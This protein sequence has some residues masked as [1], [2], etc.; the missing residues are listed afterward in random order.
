MFEINNDLGN[1]K[2]KSWHNW[3]HFCASIVFVITVYYSYDHKDIIISGLTAWAVGI[4]WDVVDGFKPWY[5]QFK[6]NYEQPKW[7]NWLRQNFN[8]S[9]KFSLQ[10]ILVWDLAG[11]LAG[12]G[13][14]LLIN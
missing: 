3:F 14:L 9:D 1:I 5:Y 7:L 8:Y 12:M 11:C 6:Y 2:Y 13:L 10:D 4:M